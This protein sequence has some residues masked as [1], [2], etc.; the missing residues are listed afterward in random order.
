MVLTKLKMLH[1]GK[2]ILNDP[3]QKKNVRKVPR[4]SNQLHAH[5]P[6]ERKT[7]L[8]KALLSSSSF[9]L[10]NQSQQP[11]S[12][13]DDDDDDDDFGEDGCCCCFGCFYCCSC[14]GSSTFIP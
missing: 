14:C 2:A 11:T 10:L 7:Y 4:K 9:A 3:F 1:H 6:K 5:T 8:P 13:R 12:E